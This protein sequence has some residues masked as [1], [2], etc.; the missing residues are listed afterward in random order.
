MGVDMDPAAL[1][2]AHQR[3]LAKAPPGTVISR[4]GGPPPQQADGLLGEEGCGGSPPGATAAECRLVQGNFSDVK[5]I[6]KSFSGK[7]TP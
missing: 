2:I 5:E 1:D 4:E 7:L 6:L 3:L